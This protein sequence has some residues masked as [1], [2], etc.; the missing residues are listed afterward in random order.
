[1]VDDWSVEDE[2]LLLT[3]FMIFET[4]VVVLDGQHVDVDR[5]GFIGASRRSVCDRKYAG[6]ETDET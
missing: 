6:G 3:V 4:R 5:G 1:M 2:V